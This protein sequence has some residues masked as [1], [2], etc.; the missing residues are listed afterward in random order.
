MK[1]TTLCALLLLAPSIFPKNSIAKNVLTHQADQPLDQNEKDD[2]DDFFSNFFAQVTENSKTLQNKIVEKTGFLNNDRL[3]EMVFQYFLRS[4]K[5]SSLFIQ[6]LR[7]NCNK[8]IPTSN[9]RLD[10]S[11]QG[12]L[13]YITKYYEDYELSSAHNGPTGWG[14]V[15]PAPPSSFSWEKNC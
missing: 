4:Q 12:L 11:Q 8:P 15:Y 6:T 5:D 13:N 3:A 10:E 7:D 2:L 14:S 1:L 9:D